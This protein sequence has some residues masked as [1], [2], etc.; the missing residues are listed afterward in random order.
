M[1]DNSFLVGIRGTLHM[2]LVIPN[3][4]LLLFIMTS[5]FILCVYMSIHTQGQICTVFSR[6]GK[7]LEL[8]GNMHLSFFFIKSYVFSYDTFHTLHFIATWGTDV[9]L[10]VSYHFKCPFCFQ[11]LSSVQYQI[12]LQRIFFL[13]QMNVQQEEQSYLIN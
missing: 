1:Q 6:I 3:I 2:P 13:K 9:L 10:E 11:F 12:C 5:Y 8:E 4:T 7:Y